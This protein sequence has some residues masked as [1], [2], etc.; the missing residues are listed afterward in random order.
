MAKERTCFCCGKTYKYC[1]NCEDDQNSETWHFMFDSENCKII[2]DAL[3]KYSCGDISKEKCAKI[4]NSC[5][6]SEKDSFHENILADINS[7]LSFN[8]P[9]SSASPQKR[10]NRSKLKVSDETRV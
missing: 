1:P 5:D 10:G 2:F 6:L 9:A 3:Q 4:L 8:H 7:V